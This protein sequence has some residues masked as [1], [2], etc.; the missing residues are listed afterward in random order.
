MT[1][2]RTV[3]VML[4]QLIDLFALMFVFGLQ[5]SA[6]IMAY[7]FVSICF[8]FCVLVSVVLSVIQLIYLKTSLVT[9]GN[10]V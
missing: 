8:F 4:L 2:S 7:C 10:H 1:L 3:Q 6:F 5:F 9:A